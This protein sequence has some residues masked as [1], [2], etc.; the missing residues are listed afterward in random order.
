[1]NNITAKAV[2]EEVMK[3]QHDSSIWTKGVENY[4]PLPVLWKADLAET[5]LDYTMKEEKEGE[6]SYGKN[7]LASGGRDRSRNP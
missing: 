5:D 6:N 1:M 7:S 2:M 4:T 3:N